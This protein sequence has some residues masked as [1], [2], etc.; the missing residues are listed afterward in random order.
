MTPSQRRPAARTHTPRQVV[1]QKVKQLEG[2]LAEAMERER[3]SS[4]RVHTLT[5][6]VRTKDAAGVARAGGCR[7]GTGGRR[8]WGR[9][10]MA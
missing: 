9:G 7:N 5:E 6:V 1:T 10:F 3:K 8:N 2:Q 4:V